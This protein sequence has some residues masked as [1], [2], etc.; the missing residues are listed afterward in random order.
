MRRASLSPT[1]N[2]QTRVGYLEAAYRIW[3]AF[4][5]S[6][7]KEQFQTR[8]GK[9]PNRRS[10]ISIIGVAE[11][12]EGTRSQTVKRE[13]HEI[14][15]E[16]TREEHRLLEVFH[17]ATGLGLE[18]IQ[19]F[20]VRKNGLMRRKQ[21]CQVSPVYHRRLTADPR[22]ATKWRICG[23]DIFCFYRSALCIGLA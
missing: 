4:V 5:S 11:V 1:D 3:C 20:I 21:T 15:Y 2:L 14:I 19:K 6:L 23:S 10:K 9:G 17:S 7:T 18:E 12:W 22:C 13:A 16:Q 8:Y